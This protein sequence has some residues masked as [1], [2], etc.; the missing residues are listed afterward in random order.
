MEIYLNISVLSYLT[1]F[2]KLTYNN[3]E[4]IIRSYRLERAME[5]KILQNITLKNETVIYKQIIYAVDIHR[6]AMEL[7]FIL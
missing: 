4:N 2:M 3:K 5:I 1:S 6:K 7:V